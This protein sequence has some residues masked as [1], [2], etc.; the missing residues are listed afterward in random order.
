MK[1]SIFASLLLIVTVLSFGCKKD[2][3]NS[4]GL[5]VNIN[6]T[7]WVAQITT[8]TYQAQSNILLIMGTNSTATEGVSLGLI[9]GDVG[10]YNFSDD[11]V[12]ASGGYHAGIGEDY[13][14]LSGLSSVGQ[15]VITEFDKTNLTVSGTFHFEAFNDKNVKKTFTDGKFNKIKYI[16][17]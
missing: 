3:E 17:Q 8:A 5:S 6:G 16:A 2:A 13:L 4:P 7:A 1:K 15:I 10:T 9:A 11:N 14:S 12:D